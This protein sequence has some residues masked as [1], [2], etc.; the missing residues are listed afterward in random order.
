M[1]GAQL[2]PVAL[3]EGVS[4]T[5]GWTLLFGAFVTIGLVTGMAVL[6]PYLLTETLGL[7]E[8]RQG[9]ALGTLTVLNEVVLILA[10]GPLGALSDR[11]GRRPIHVAGFL[12][13]AAA[14]LLFPLARSLAEF[15]ALRLLCAP[16]IGA[17]TGLYGVLLADHAVDRA[18]AL[19]RAS[20]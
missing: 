10:Y 15:G 14:C 8:A 17:A 3:E 1:S 7:D 6:T 12:A 2:G 16:G 19:R 13:M 9:R 4:R 5:N 11:F 18:A 20:G